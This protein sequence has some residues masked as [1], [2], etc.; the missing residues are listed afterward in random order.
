MMI[1]GHCAKINMGEAGKL[2][3]VHVF[4][5]KGDIDLSQLLPED[6]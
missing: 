3:Q 4:D 2:V 5:Q 6:N 1:V